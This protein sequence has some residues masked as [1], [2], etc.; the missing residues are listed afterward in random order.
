MLVVGE[1]RGVKFLNLKKKA[2][3][4]SGEITW[5]LALAELHDAN[6]LPRL[7]SFDKNNISTRTLRKM[8]KYTRD[9]RFTPESVEKVSSAAGAFW[10]GDPHSLQSETEVRMIRMIRGVSS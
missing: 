3:W 4:T 10:V 1:L 7:T 5:E 6:F 9:A 2:Y 8:E